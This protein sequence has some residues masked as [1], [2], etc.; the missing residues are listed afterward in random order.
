MSL[1]SNTYGA[2]GDWLIGTVKRNPE[3]FL[4]L[5]AGCALMMRGP[6]RNGA[7]NPPRDNYYG[8]AA[9]QH[10]GDQGRSWGDNVSRLAEGATRAGESA[11]DYASNVTDSVSETIG[12]Y[13]SS[14][15]DYAHD[16]GRTIADRASQLT[17]SA[18]STIEQRAAQ[19]LREQPLAVAVFG[20]AA[21]AALAA[22]FP[23]TEAEAQALGP[24]R[25]AIYDAANK[26]GAS[27]KEAAGEA[28]TRLK[29]AASEHGLS[30]EGLKDIAREA[31]GA[32]SEKVEGAFDTQRTPGSQ[33]ASGSQGAQN[34][35][36]SQGSQGSQGAQPG[37]LGGGLR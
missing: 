7:V 35:Q 4:V 11:K 8:D 26:A 34:G 15:S 36:G 18:Q 37:T 32:F 16:A 10:R 2:T 30:A 6:A 25:D 28:G 5:A 27:L 12:S 24:A 21:G 20:L 23:S 19:V 9:R 13:A 3:A 14:V 1:N 31:A 33:G 29:E 22:I 17:S